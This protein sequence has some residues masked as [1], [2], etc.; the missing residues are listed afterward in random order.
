MCADLPTEFNGGHS[1]VVNGEVYFGGG[2]TDERHE[3]NEYIVHS[4]K[5]AQDKWTTLPPLPIRYFGLGQ[6]NG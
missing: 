5:P 2:N 6:I 4:Y 1:V 3:Y